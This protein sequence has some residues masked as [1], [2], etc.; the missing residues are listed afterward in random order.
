MTMINMKKKYLDR[1]SLRK[2]LNDFVSKTP[3]CYLMF[4][5]FKVGPIYLYDETD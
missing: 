2:I 5:K 1:I 3:V 4:G